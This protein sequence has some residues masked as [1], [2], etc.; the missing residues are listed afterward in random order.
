MPSPSFTHS[1]RLRARQQTTDDP[2]LTKAAKAVFDGAPLETVASQ[3]SI[4]PEVI[5]ARLDELPVITRNHSF[6]TLDSMRKAKY[7][8]EKEGFS[9]QA[10]AHKVGI[11]RTCLANFLWRNNTRKDFS[12][13]ELS[14]AATALYNGEMGG[15]RAQNVYKIM[16]SSIEYVASQIGAGTYKSPGDYDYSE[17]GMLAAMRRVLID[18]KPIRDIAEEC[19]VP[20]SAL[21][22]RVD[23]YNDKLEYDNLMQTQPKASKRWK[24]CF[25]KLPQASSQEIPIAEPNSQNIP[26]HNPSSRHTVSIVPHSSDK[27]N[28]GPCESDSIK[29]SVADPMP[30]DPGQTPGNGCPLFDDKPFLL[31]KPLV[32]PKG[33]DGFPNVSMSFGDELEFYVSGSEPDKK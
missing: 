16:K 9:K 22:F 29:N 24:K 23:N 5:K 17:K 10:A 2:I 4:K 7:L 15:M 32:E 1:K 13:E 3:Y 25:R 31:Q 14:C 21:K 8:V 30:V 28:T 11:T 12:V 33:F 6:E 26:E 18:D 27:P 20:E 19:N